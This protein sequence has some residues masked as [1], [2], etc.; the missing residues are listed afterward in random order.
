M[1]ER[2]PLPAAWRGKAL[3]ML[4]HGLRGLRV[5]HDTRRLFPFLALTAVIWSLDVAGTMMA[6]RAMGLAM[7]LPVALLLLAGLGLGS[8][9]PA[10]PGYAGIYQFVA[11]SVLTP[12]GFTRTAAVAFILLAQTLSYL[13]MGVCGALGFWRYRRMAR[14]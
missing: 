4:R 14:P 13:V 12:F 7:T 9:L 5:F 3:N 1:L 8:A 11:V 6:A 2:A 10:M